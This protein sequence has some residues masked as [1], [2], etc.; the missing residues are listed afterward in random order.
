MKIRGAISDSNKNAAVRERK[1]QIID[2]LINSH[3]VSVTSLQEQ[4]VHKEEQLFEYYN[5]QRVVI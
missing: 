4:I 2:R 1:L 5:L 3:L